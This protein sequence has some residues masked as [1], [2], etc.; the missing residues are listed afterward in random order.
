MKAME[1]SAVISQLK[2]LVVA[3]LNLQRIKAADIADEVQ[4]FGSDG[5]GLD[6]LDAL[7]FGE[8]IERDFSVTLPRDDDEL[9]PLMKSVST[10]ADFIL[11]SRTEG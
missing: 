3:E 6:S 4:L 10:I 9:R 8:A 2:D 1:R 5:L 11:R 7:Q